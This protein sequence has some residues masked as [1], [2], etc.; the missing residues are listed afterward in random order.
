MNTEEWQG[1]V[2]SCFLNFIFSYCTLN[3]RHLKSYQNCWDGRACKSH[4]AK[5]FISLLYQ[6]NFLNL[7]GYRTPKYKTDGKCSS[8]GLRE[9][10]TLGLIPCSRTLQ[11][12]SLVTVDLVNLTNLFKVFLKPI[13]LTDDNIASSTIF[14]ETKDLVTYKRGNL[15]GKVG[16]GMY[17]L[18]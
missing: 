9:R 17:P 12:P 2:L 5:Q 10:S 7:I 11:C 16:W 13:F 6:Q 1:Y 4:L 15:G 18:L 14:P 8:S 3:S